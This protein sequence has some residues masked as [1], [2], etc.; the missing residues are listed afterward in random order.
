[1]FWITDEMVQAMVR[2]RVPAAGEPR[3]IAPPRKRSESGV[4]EVLRA[5]L[6]AIE[7]MLHDNQTPRP[8][9]TAR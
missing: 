3:F 7:A 9:F 6:R 4:G 8:A 1:M 5:A 2:E